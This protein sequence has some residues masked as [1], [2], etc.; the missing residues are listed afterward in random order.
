MDIVFSLSTKYKALD[1][2]KILIVPLIVF[3]KNYLTNVLGMEFE[4]AV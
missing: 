1:L 4:F 2:K 3:L